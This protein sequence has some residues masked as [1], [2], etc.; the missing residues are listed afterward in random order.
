MNAQNHRAGACGVPSR[1]GYM[2]YGPTLPQTYTMV[3]RQPVN[4]PPP[5]PPPTTLGRCG[6]PGGPGPC[7]EPLAECWATFSVSQAIPA[8]VGQL[9]V[10]ALTTDTFT[11]YTP[12][13]IQSHSAAGEHF[14]AQ[15][16]KGGSLF[17]D[18]P[19]VV[20]E[21]YRAVGRDIIPFPGADMDGGRA[22]FFD[23]RLALN[24]TLVNRLIGIVT[25]EFTLW[26]LAVR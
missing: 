18:P 12:K 8:G 2:Y 11:T 3:G 23:R 13:F 1:A 16:E 25:A 9:A 20:N 22:P 19:G 6:T 21:A 5:T 4:G 7:E 17:L 10:A 14:F 24:I 15:I 26:G